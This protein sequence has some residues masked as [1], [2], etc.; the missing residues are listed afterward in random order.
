MYKACVWSI[1][2]YCMYCFAWDWSEALGL[3][4]GEPI[5]QVRAQL[6]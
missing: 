3:E 5:G 6:M 1:A 2:V 4:P